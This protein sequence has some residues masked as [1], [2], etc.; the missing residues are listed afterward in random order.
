[1]DLLKITG[2][3]EHNLKNISLEIPKN[4]LIV[5]TGVSGSGKS[6]LAFDT[7]YAEGQRRY[8]ESL[9][10]YARQFLGKL[11]KPEVE[12][13]EGLAP[14]IAIEQK[15]AS[16][17]P[18]STVGTIT[19]VYDFLRVLFAR[20]GEP[21]CPDC[22]IPIKGYTLDEVVERV[23]SHP[24]EKAIFLSPVV[25]ERK[26]EYRKLFETIKRDGFL[27]ARVNGEI[28]NLEDAIPE[29]D[30]KRKHS[31]EI[32]IDR[33]RIRADD[34]ARIAEGVEL[35]LKKG[36]GN[37]I[38]RLPDK[39]EELLFSEHHSCPECG[40]SFPEL[41]P[42][43]FSFNSPLGMCQRCHGLAYI[44]KFDVEKAIADPG[45]SLHDGALRYFGKLRDKKDSWYY[46]LLS[47]LAGKIEF[48][49][50][51]PYRQLSEKARQAIF[52]GD[53]K[54]EI[55][56]G[57]GKERT[58]L[59]YEGLANSIYRLYHETSSEENREFYDSFLEEEICPDCR[60]ARLRK[61]AL[62]I[63]ICGKN[64]HALTDLSIDKLLSYFRELNLSEEKTRIAQVILREITGRLSFL[65]NVGLNYLTLSRRAP[66]LSGGEAQRIRLASQIGSGLTGVIYVLDEPSIGL[67]Q[68]DN[69]MLLDTLKKLRDLGNTVIVVEHDEETMRESDFLVDFG[70]GAGELGGYIVAAGTPEDVIGVEKSVTAKYLRGDLKIESG[71][72]K[73]LS[74]KRGFL[75]F[76]GA[77]EHNLKNI[78][79]RFP[80][81]KISVITGVSGS[82]KSTLL[83]EII[84]KG[85]K[86]KISGTGEK[87]GRF[88]QITG[89]SG[90][91]KILN[92]DQDPIG[93]TPRSNPIIYTGGFTGIRDIFASLPESKKR[94]YGP[95]RFSFNVRGGRCEACQGGGRKRIELLFLPDVYVTCEVCKGRRFNSETLAVSFKGKNISEILEMSVDEAWELFQPF[96]NV[97]RYLETLREV[98][99]GY[100]RL[101][102][103]ATTLS[104]GEAQRIKLARELTK[105]SRG[106]TIYL[107]D[108]PTTGLH[109]ADV[110]K[111]IK[112]LQK[113][114]EKGNTLII[115]EHNLDVIKVADYILDLGPEGGEAGGQVVFNGPLP[116]ILSEKKSFTGQFLERH[117]RREK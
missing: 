92:I 8:I 32:V 102:Q 62:A 12:S 91:Q 48:S 71:S 110:D 68:K 47:S 72:G 79:V 21:Y 40:F 10:A 57:K 5:F 77:A 97:R 81:G 100:I 101:G 63:R 25:R 87:P 65:T 52:Y 22:N 27:R 104:G 36:H 56:W 53:Q 30:K 60:G 44:K 20:I 2:A 96:P 78:D 59:R 9:S 37:F 43:L 90:I 89:S 49:M 19:E 98:G 106:D 14:A 34:R 76:T 46:R 4:R 109:F 3:R 105:V 64:I 13:L 17:N 113:L 95:G 108:E 114:S 1:M 80:L 24:E 111:L 67:H 18:R 86:R 75:S 73:D 7:I 23:L 35:A 31:I 39:S 42:Q 103:P 55:T 28:I 50:D 85:L 45:L 15:K 94:G 117:L 51:T 11:E 107:L 66:S 16:N 116:G 61:E 6:S 29:L 115:I 26:G 33:L 84:Y 69:K 112:V 58:T 70:P 88:K 93:R 41:N 99:L 38:L 74:F 82:G 83:Y 54:V